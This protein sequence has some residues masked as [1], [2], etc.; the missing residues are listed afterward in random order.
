MA[1]PDGWAYKRTISLSP[2]TPQAN[3]QVKIEL[4]PDNFDYSHANLNGDDLRFCQTDG[5][6]LDYWIEKWDVSGTSLVWVEVVTAGTDKISMYFGNLSAEAASNGAN[7]FEFFDDFEYE[8]WDKDLGNHVEHLIIH[9]NKLY[10]PANGIWVLE[11]DGTVLHHYLSGSWVC[12]APLVIGDYIYVWLYG[13]TSHLYKIKESDGSSSSISADGIDFEHLTVANVSGI[14]LIFTPLN[15]VVTAIRADTLEVYW[16]SSV[17]VSDTTHH[18]DGGLVVGNYLYTRQVDDNNHKLVKL[19]LSDGTIADS[20][21][22][23]DQNYYA[24]LL[25]DIDHNQIIL[26]E[27]KT[28][29]VKA[30]D[31]DDF[32]KLNWTKTLDETDWSI[33]Y[34]PSYHNDQV[35]VVDRTDNGDQ[36]YIYCLNATNGDQIWKSSISYNE[37]VSIQNTVLSDKYLFCPTYDYYDGNYH[38]TLVV[39]IS[40]GSLF[41]TIDQ[42]DGSS[43]CCPVV[44]SGMIYLGMWDDYQINAR[45][46][47]SGSALDCGYKV[48]NYRT[49]YVGDRLTSYSPA[50]SLSGKWTVNGSPAISFSNGVIKLSSADEWGHNIESNSA[51]SIPLIIR[52][53]INYEDDITDAWQKVLYYQTND[54]AFG[55]YADKWTYPNAI[56]GQPSSDIQNPVV[57]EN[58]IYEYT[59]LSDHLHVEVTKISSGSVVASGDSSSISPNSPDH[60]YLDAINNIYVDW[61]FVRKY[62]SSEPIATPGGEIPIGPSPGISLFWSDLDPVTS[63]LRSILSLCLVSL[64]QI[65]YYS[66]FLLSLSTTGDYISYLDGVSLNLCFNI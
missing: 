16:S 49:G 56:G 62:A 22:L 54:Y 12:C 33:W 44:S 59:V 47:G 60:I 15:G 29:K 37:K 8:G 26:T 43:C 57:G 27:H 18:W 55:S 1:F 3:Y 41:D 6:L 30:Y 36:S 65:W 34:T 66:L 19:N 17:S 9:D 52:A 64:L 63:V 21:A 28:L 20:V 46:I 35:Y 24:S 4:T 31:A 58:Y 2:A 42:T 53:K 50:K 14:D 13:S 61:V 38:K 32:S 45:K 5:T 25:Y 11:L 51:I 23:E 40:D 48:D 10:S 39:D 7:T